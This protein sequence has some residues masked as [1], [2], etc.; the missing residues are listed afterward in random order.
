MIAVVTYMIVCHHKRHAA[1]LYG[2][3]CVYICGVLL[4]GHQ[5]QLGSTCQVVTISINRQHISIKYSVGKTT[6]IISDVIANFSKIN[7]R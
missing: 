5:Q 7:I 6:L 3:V 1:N 2:E 4:H